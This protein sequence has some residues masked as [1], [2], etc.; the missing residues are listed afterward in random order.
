MK[1]F[2][3][4]FL[5]I[6]AFT[7]PRARAMEEVSFSIEKPT[8]IEKEFNE[9]AE[10][11]TTAT[12][13]EAIKAK[14]EASSD[15]KALVTHRESILVGKNR[16]TL[17]HLLISSELEDDIKIETIKLFVKSGAD[18][19]AQDGSCN[20]LLLDAIA[21]DSSI[22]IITTLIEL[23]THL[24]RKEGARQTPLFLAIEKNNVEIVR[25]LIEKGANV[26]EHFNS[27]DQ[28]EELSNLTPLHHAIM[29]GCSLEIIELLIQKG[30][31]IDALYR[32][33]DSKDGMSVTPLF[34]AYLTE[35][36]E[37]IQLLLEYGANQNIECTYTKKEESGSIESGHYSSCTRTPTAKVEYFHTS[38][39]FNE[40]SL[41]NNQTLFATKPNPEKIKLIKGSTSSWST[42]SKVGLTFA[43]VA[44]GIGAYCLYKKYQEKKKRDQEDQKRKAAQE[45][46]EKLEKMEKEM[47]SQTKVVAIPTT[48]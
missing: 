5:L 40:S 1:K 42:P 20:T 33:K 39:F 36:E 16:E 21:K 24:Q 34:L 19:N 48:V 15:K 38:S 8:N 4:L 11:F 27:S 46:I 17:L 30:A 43:V 10:L 18:I 37:L 26:N 44:T 35:W 7:S 32:E 31:D 29:K 41:K 9:F 22:E 28:T 2:L 14:L 12:T 3:R 47:S 25:L 13:F 23:G 45:R 6:T